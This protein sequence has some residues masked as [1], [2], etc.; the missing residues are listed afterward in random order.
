MKHLS[1]DQVKKFRTRELTTEEL[2]D[3][4]DHLSQ[5]EGCRSQLFRPNQTEALKNSLMNYSVD[6]VEHLQFEQLAS[7]VDQKLHASEQL[8][9]ENHLKGCELCS[10]EV[11]DLKAFRNTMPKAEKAEADKIIPFQRKQS[12]W[13]WVAAI[14][15]VI[16]LAMTATLVWNQN[17]L[18]RLQS[19]LTKV[20][21]QNVKLQREIEQSRGNEASVVFKDGSSELRI[22]K[23]GHVM[24]ALSIPIQ[25]QQAISNVVQDRKFN[26]PSQ[27]TNMFGNKEIIRGNTEELPFELISPVATAVATDRPVF[28]WQSLANAK[29]YQVRI[30]DSDF[31]SILQS[32]WIH[33]TEWIA[34]QG[35]PVGMT[36]IWQVAAR[37]DN[38]E[39]ISPFAPFPDAKFRILNAD[40]TA[41]VQELRNKYSNFHLILGVQFVQ[42]GLLDD[43]QNE[44]IELQ[45]LNPDSKEASALLNSFNNLRAAK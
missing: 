26:I 34:N 40:E 7:Y 41:K 6:E 27:V 30:F 38:Q 14:A 45:K 29:A 37:K 36:L 9:I 10:G 33:E 19:R 5:C 4:D 44:F 2:F 31:R 18:Q 28:R 21:S 25:E 43:A 16:A 22:Q 39:I 24:A 1:A 15:A 23:D 12:N 3:V 32:Q 42:F 20:E 17:R 35:L 13:G 8:E 11:E